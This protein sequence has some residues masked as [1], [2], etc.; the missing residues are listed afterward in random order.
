MVSEDEL[1]SQLEEQEQVAD[2]VTSNP[3]EVY[4]SFKGLKKGKT[5]MVDDSDFTNKKKKFFN[6]SK[7]GTVLAFSA[8]HGSRYCPNCGKRHGQWFKVRSK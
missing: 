4:G 7:C 3:I 6:C 2:D 5:K 1:L 8:I